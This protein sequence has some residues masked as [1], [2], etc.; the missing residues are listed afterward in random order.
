MDRTE[1]FYKID[2]LLSERQ[3]VPMAL[4]QERLEVSRATIKRDLEYLRNRLN[5]PIVWDR[6][7]QGYRFGSPEQAGLGAGARYELPGLWFS[8]EEI[9]ALLTMQ[10]LLANLDRGGLLGAQVEPLQARLRGL[11]GSA[12]NPAEEVQKRVRILGMAARATPLDQFSLV[13]AALL[14]RKRL[15]ISYFARGKGEASD[16]EISPLRLIHYRDNWYLDAWCHLRQ[17]LRSFSLDALRSVKLLEEAALDVPEDKLDAELG[18]GYGIFSGRELEWARLRFTP[19]R[20][21][22]VAS[23]TW[24]PKQK[25]YFD[26]D[27]SYILELPYSDDRELT[28]DILRHGREVEVL[29]PATLRRRVADELQAAFAGYS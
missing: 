24:H 2:Q 12:H 20:A 11:L 22:W 18:A 5:A 8:S 26:A 9:L 14:N 15:F 25:G 13:G 16:R 6:Q 23:E 27:G 21:R 28:M 29:A 19:H 7:A 3:V 1:R 4:L 17:G 10:H